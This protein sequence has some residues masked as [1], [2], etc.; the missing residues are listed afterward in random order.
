MGWK[1]HLQDRGYGVDESMSA[2]IN[3]WWQWY[4]A[5]HAFY[6]DTTMSGTRTFKVERISI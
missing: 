4:T 3:T 6:A 2:A 1:S 5:T